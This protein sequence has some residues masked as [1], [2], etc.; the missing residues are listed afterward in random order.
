MNRSREST[1]TRRTIQR[2]LRPNRGRRGGVGEDPP[3]A[4]GVS[5]ERLSSG[6][7][8]S[9]HVT[10]LGSSAASP[11]KSTHVTSRIVTSTISTDAHAGAARD[12]SGALVRRRRT[13][14]TSVEAPHAA[15]VPIGSRHLAAEDVREQ[16]CDRVAVE[17][18]HGSR[19]PSR[20]RRAEA[21]GPDARRVVAELDE[22]ARR[23]LDE[24]GRAADV[25]E[26]PLARAATTRPRAAPGRS[27]G[28][29]RASPRAARGSA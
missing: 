26:R 2:G 25:R 12:R 6:G 29:S 15:H 10:P 16:T 21:L 14:A 23:G 28:R 3:G 19:R 7:G 17:R 4:G 5:A 1:A 20:S 18:R 8:I 24:R 27:A 9:D 11:R 22:R 13:V